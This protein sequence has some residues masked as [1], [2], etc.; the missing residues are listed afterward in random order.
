MAKVIEFYVPSSFRRKLQW[1]GVEERGQVIEFAV[2]GRGL[3]AEKGEQR[4]C[5]FAVEGGLQVC[6]LPEFEF[7]DVS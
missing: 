3:V 2:V 4:R 1:H 7:D 6:L 5:L